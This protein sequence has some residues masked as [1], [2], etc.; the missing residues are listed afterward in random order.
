M[1]IRYF[2][3]PSYNE[4]KLYLGV[5]NTLRSERNPRID[6][7]IPITTWFIMQ[8][9]LVTINISLIFSKY[10]VFCYDIQEI[11]QD[12]GPT[13]YRIIWTMG[14]LIIISILLRLFEVL[15]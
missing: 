9:K 10:E 5:F 1:I 7:L 11:C 2:K 4:I 14:I 12:M 6:L 15:I 13:N 3:K 8:T